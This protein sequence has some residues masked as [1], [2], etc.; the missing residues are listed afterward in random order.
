MAALTAAR[1]VLVARGTIKKA[2][3]PLATGQKVWANGLCV[4]D[5]AN[6]GAV[7]KGVS[8]STTLKPIGWFLDSYD[9][10]SGG[11]TV[12][13]GVEL[14]REREISYWDAAGTGA[15]TASNLFGTV[16][17]SSDHELFTTSSG[18][19]AFGLMWVYGIQGY[20]NAI[21]VEALF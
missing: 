9:N 2:T 11:T 15:P 17:I 6:L 16:Y 20:P 10:T 3:F 8:G 13:I 4:I 7:Y 19:S 18:N 21:G 14:F 5:S 1:T 12:P